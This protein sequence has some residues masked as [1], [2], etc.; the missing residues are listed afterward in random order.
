MS[1]LCSYAGGFD[2][3]EYFSAFQKRVPMILQSEAPECGIACVAMV[4]SYHGH[5]TDL[6]AMRTRLSPSLKGI[7]LKQVSQVAETMGLAS[8]GVKA[9]MAAL[10]K[11]ELPAV[12]HWDMNHFVV[13]TK[14][15]AKSITVNDPGRGV[16]QLK[17]SEV[18]KHYTGVAME[19]TP[20]P[21]FKPQDE[22]NKVGAFQL[23]SAGSGLGNA[24]AQLVMLSFAI[25]I[26]AI[27]MPFFLATHRRSGASRA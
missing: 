19:F 24:V 15:R 2:G 10:A 7:T 26:F 13:L 3:L 17:F 4:A 11:L 1:Q 8:R 6:I 18:S 12:L 14:V 16:R 23:L 22:R 25:E 20:T 21:S 27:A 5:A 9:E